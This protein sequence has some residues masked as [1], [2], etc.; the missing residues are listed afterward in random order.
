MSPTQGDLSRWEETKCRDGSEGVSGSDRDTSLTTTSEGRAWSP[1]NDHEQGIGGA[2]SPEGDRGVAECDGLVYD[3]RPILPKVAFFIGDLRDGLCM[4]RN[5]PTLMFAGTDVN[6]LFGTI[7]L[8]NNHLPTLQF[9][10]LA[11][12][13][14]SCIFRFQSRDQ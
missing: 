8:T 12:Q 2:A 3:A 7:S 13:H 5:G 9:L 1:S 14:A 11:A 6:E 4:V 10:V